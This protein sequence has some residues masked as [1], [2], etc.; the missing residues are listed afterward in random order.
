M[1]IARLHFFLR[2]FRLL[3]SMVSL[4]R[5]FTDSAWLFSVGWVQLQCVVKTS[6]SCFLWTR[7]TLNL[8][9]N[10]FWYL[11][12]HSILFCVMVARGNI[13]SSNVCRICSL[14]LWCYKKFHFKSSELLAL[15]LISVLS[16]SLSFAFVYCCVFYVPKKALK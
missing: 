16:A 3:I 2:L 11:Y 4:I 13:F 6:S 12:L 14:T 1:D 15:I 7:L 9:P 10:E 5:S 8:I